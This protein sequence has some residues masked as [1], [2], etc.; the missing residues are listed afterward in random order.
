MVGFNH[1]PYGY[2]QCKSTRAIFFHRWP[3]VNFYYSQCTVT[4]RVGS[5]RLFYYADKLRFFFSQSDKQLTRKPAT[6]WTPF[7]C[8]LL[9]IEL[10]ALRHGIEHLPEIRRK[11]EIYFWKRYHLPWSK[12]GTCHLLEGGGGVGAGLVQFFFPR[13][14]FFMPPPISCRKKCNPPPCMAKN[15][16]DPPHA[17]RYD[18]DY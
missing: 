17:K 13:W 2:E 16:Y 4:V 18:R 1:H 7:C 5:N 9:S 10:A 12:L 11:R 14:I 3:P 15:S 8:W 6:S